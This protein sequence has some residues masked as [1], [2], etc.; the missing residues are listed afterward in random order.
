MSAGETE[1]E[2]TIA[3]DGTLPA[4]VLD[5]L[6]RLAKALA[7]GEDDEV[8]GFGQ[9]RG[10]LNIGLDRVGREGFEPVT[11]GFCLGY[12]VTSE[13]N[14]PDTCTIKWV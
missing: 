10:N 1:L 11:T 13:P 6:D 7:S 14:T 8:A 2:I 12:T 3:A 4:T 5:A 9:S